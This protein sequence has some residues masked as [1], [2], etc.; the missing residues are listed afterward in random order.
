M[1]IE[2]NELKS[3]AYDYQLQ[4]IVEN[5]NDILLIGINAAIEEMSGYLSGRY[6]CTAIF[7]TTGPDRNPLIV[8]LG[9]NIALWYIIR[10][11]NVDILHD[12]AKEGYDRAIEWLNKV[13][14][15]IISPNLPIAVTD[16]GEE[17]NPI[18]TGSMDKQSYDW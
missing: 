6:N 10:L 13:A 11:A 12:K 18:R 5:D 2:P 7:T 17:T 3:V 14:T 9:K 15:G 4:Q 16:S 8:E 1:F